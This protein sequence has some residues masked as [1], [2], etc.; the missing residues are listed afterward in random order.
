[1]FLGMCLVTD[2][3]EWYKSSLQEKRG[4]MWKAMGSS[5][6]SGDK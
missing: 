6:R 1:M 5:N 2:S 3:R 4:K